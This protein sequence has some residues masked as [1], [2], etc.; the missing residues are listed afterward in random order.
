MR[1]APL[2]NVRELGERRATSASSGRRPG[3]WGGACRSCRP[4][5][6][7]ALQGY[8]RRPVEARVDGAHEAFAEA[9]CRGSLRFRR[10]FGGCSARRVVR[11]QAG[12]EG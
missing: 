7:V 1:A 6:G 9:R 8:V 11:S 2:R 5:E 10:R 12:R 3:R 4:S